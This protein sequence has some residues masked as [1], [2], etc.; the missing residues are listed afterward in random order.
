MDSHAF[1]PDMAPGQRSGAENTNMNYQLI[2][3]K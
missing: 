2:C 3:D 1:L